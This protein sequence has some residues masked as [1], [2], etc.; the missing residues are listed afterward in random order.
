MKQSGKSNQQPKSDPNLQLRD[1]GVKRFYEWKKGWNYDGQ[2]TMD[3]N[4]HGQGKMKW[5]NGTSYEGQYYLDAREGQGECHF[6]N[7]DVYKG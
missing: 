2:F 3:N 7:G 1:E 6:A 4:R 5:P